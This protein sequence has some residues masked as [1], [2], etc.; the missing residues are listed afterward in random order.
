MRQSLTWRP[1]AWPL[2]G[3][4]VLSLLSAPYAFLTAPEQ[5]AK[6]RLQQARPS[7]FFYEAHAFPASDANA[8]LAPRSWA[9][10]RRW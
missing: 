7:R 9:S 1:L 4:S 2:A 6:S 5:S 10:R 3:R 8:R